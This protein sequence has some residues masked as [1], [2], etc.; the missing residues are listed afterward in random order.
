MKRLSKIQIRLIKNLS[1]NG[2]SLRKI[3]K[4]TN[5][6]LSTIQYNLNVNKKVKRVKQI[7]LLFPD[8][9]KGEIIGSFAGDGSYYHDKNGRSSKYY[10]RYFLSY[11]DD[12]E[13]KNYLVSLFKKMGLNPKVYVKNYKGN[14]SSF[15]IRISSIN[16]SNF[17]KDYLHW[18]NRKVY[19]IRLAKEIE[20]HNKSFLFG[21]AR[22]LMDTDGFVE[23]INIS[24]GVVSKELIEDLRKILLILKIV[25]RITVRK[26]DN[27]KDLYLLRIPRKYL[28][29]YYKNIGFSNKRKEEGLLKIMGL[30]GFE[31]GSQGPKPRSLNQAS[32]QSL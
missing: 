26:R 5:I 21:F 9:I 22:G 3:Q 15:E 29:I 30:P 12:K 19:S 11:K 10:T 20:S 4:K 6:T 13:Y 31:P 16:L 25:P 23:N 7:N 18:E 2:L 27:R 8:F 17:I 1:K 14:P 24:C 32:R 28:E